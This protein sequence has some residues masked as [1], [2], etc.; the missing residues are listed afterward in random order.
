MRIKSE[1]SE[2]LKF[3]RNVVAKTTEKNGQVIV[4]IKLQF[5]S[6]PTGAVGLTYK[7]IGLYDDEPVLEKYNMG[8]FTGPIKVGTFQ[9]VSAIN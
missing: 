7:L 4:E 5:D 8:G 9:C 6:T 3:N 1:N 2:F